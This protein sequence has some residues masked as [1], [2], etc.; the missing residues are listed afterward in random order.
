VE[1]DG[2]ITKRDALDGEDEDR[3][4]NR[5][6]RALTSRE[7]QAAVR[8]LLILSEKSQKIVVLLPNSAFELENDGRV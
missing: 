5:T 8:Q 4:R 3:P 2:K 7:M 6:A 1:N